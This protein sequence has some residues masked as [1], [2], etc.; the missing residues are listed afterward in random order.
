MRTAHLK[1]FAF[2]HFCLVLK[3]MNDHL[4]NKKTFLLDSKIHLIYCCGNNYSVITTSIKLEV[5][6]TVMSSEMQNN[7]RS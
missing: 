4:Q 3:E 6:S 5:A 2:R 1:Y 7:Y